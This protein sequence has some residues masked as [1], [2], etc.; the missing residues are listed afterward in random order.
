MNKKRYSN[1]LYY[2]NR[3]T[4]TAIAVTSAAANAETSRA[5]CGLQPLV[6]EFGKFGVFT[7]FW[8][9]PEGVSL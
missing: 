6:C 1:D 4:A 7:F 3:Q 2:I 5:Y 9:R 8:I